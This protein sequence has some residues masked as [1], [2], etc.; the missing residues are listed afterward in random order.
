MPAFAGMTN[1]SELPLQEYRT[2]LF[3]DLQEV[4]DIV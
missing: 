3:Y 1:Q 4:L 2:R